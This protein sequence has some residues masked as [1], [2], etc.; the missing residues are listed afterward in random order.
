MSI[1]H[2]VPLAVL[3]LMSTAAAPLPARSAAPG[4]TPTVSA[5]VCLVITITVLGTADVVRICPPGLTPL[6]PDRAGGNG[7]DVSPY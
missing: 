4:H 5:S 6:P 3:A 2:L 1:S 7:A